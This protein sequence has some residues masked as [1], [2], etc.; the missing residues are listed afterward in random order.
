MEELKK[1]AIELLLDS[2]AVRFGEFRLK[3]GRVSPYFVN[4]GD[5]A[6]GRGISELASLMAEKIAGD[7]GLDGFDVLFGPAY[8]G[9]VL[10]S[11][12]ASSLY[13]RHGVVRGF[14]YDRKESKAHGEGGD[15]IGADLKGGRVL[16]VDDVIT[17]GGTKIEAI[18][19]LEGEAKAGVVGILVVVDRMEMSG[20][21][22]VFSKVIEE[23]RGVKVHSLI[24]VIDIIEYIEDAG[25]DGLGISAEVFAE[26]KRFVDYP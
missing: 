7:V 22:K 3:S 14:A 10:A 4:L 15:F 2:G 24:S 23:M 9:I 26:L 5:V 12:L 19:R 21:G 1:R 16:L 18:D 20:E 17:D 25:A 13:E 11:A 8:K 6:E